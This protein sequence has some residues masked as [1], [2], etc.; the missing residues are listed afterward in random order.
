MFQTG[1]GSHGHSRAGK[2]LTHALPVPEGEVLGR[3]LASLGVGLAVL[4]WEGDAALLGVSTLGFLGAG[5]RRWT[6]RLPQ[7]LSRTWVMV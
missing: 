1:H 3:G 4:L 5:A 7:G 6:P 2:G